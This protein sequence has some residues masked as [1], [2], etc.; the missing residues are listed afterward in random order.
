LTDWQDEDGKEVLYTF[1]GHAALLAREYTTAIGYLEHALRLS[2]HQ[3]IPALLLLA[4]VY[5]DRAQLMP[6]RTQPVPS[7]QVDCISMHNIQNAAPDVDAAQ[8]DTHRAISYLE[9]AT[10]LAPPHEQWQSLHFRVERELGNAYRLLGYW[11]LLK[12]DVNTGVD[13]LGAAENHLQTAL[14]GFPVATQP[15]YR[16]WTEVG[17]GTVDHLHAS[18]VERQTDRQS[19]LPLYE[20]ALGHYQACIDLRVQTQGNLVFQKK[21]LACACEPYRDLVQQIISETLASTTTITTAIS[22]TVG[23]QP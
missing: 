2:N 11:Q 13:S 15:V 1:M 6:Y 17:L 5:I 9:Q 19:A 10:A 16:A 7:A 18:A 12:G 21:V 22:T 3:Y 20:Q 4:G 14:A 23:D 8:A